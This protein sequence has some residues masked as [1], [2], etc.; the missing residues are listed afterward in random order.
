M[1]IRSS[2]EVELTGADLPGTLRA[3]Q[4]IAITEARPAGDLSLIFS[5]GRREL[6]LLEAVAEKRGVR[7]KILRKR[8]LYWSVRSLLHRPVLVLGLGLLVF[9]HFF[10]PT[11]VL[12]V[13][14]EGNEQLPKAL[15]RETAADCGLSF[16]ASRSRV[17]SEQIKNYLLG[18]L[19]QLQWAGVN[20]R[21][22][23]AVISVR[24]RSP[25]PE[26]PH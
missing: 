3:L 1:S 16:G 21:G 13:E 6:R 17:R 15:I 20:T 14:V 10:L 22:P 12:F 8:G 4:D 26:Q 18:K 23:A 2:I 11:R 25:S 19:P 24:E 9:L 7:L 5:I